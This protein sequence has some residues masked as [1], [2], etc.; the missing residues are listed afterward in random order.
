MYKL[1]AYS[2]EIVTPVNNDLLLQCNGN[3][4]ITQIIVKQLNVE[5]M[6]FKGDN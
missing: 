1:T 4:N 2:D 5:N 3:D 6:T